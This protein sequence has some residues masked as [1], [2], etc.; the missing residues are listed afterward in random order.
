MEVKESNIGYAVSTALFY[1][2]CSGSMNF[3]NK[4]VLN[5]WEFHYPNFMVLCQLTLFTAVITGLRAA[6]KLTDNVVLSYTIERG[7]QLAVLSMLYITNVILALFALSGMNIPMYNAMRRCVPIAS[8]I[9]GPCIYPQRTTTSIVGSIILITAGTITAANG[10]LDF[11]VKSYSFGI[12]SVLSQSLYLLTL[13]RMG[14]EQQLGA[15]NTASA[16]TLTILYVNSVNCVPIVFLVVLMSGEFHSLMSE[17]P[18]W[19]EPGFLFALTVV[20]SFACVFSYSIFLCTTVNSALTTACVGV[21]KSALTTIIGMYTFGGV[22][23]TPLLIIGQLINLSGGGLY[24]FEKYRIQRAR[25]AALLKQ[26][27]AK[28]SLTQ[29]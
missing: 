16:K 23:A 2:I 14:A 6:G 22:A 19:H 5:S 18:H 4:W 13:Q 27:D 8:L 10:D 28:K 26:D 25:H 11:D 17:Y 9:L 3:I 29:A 21:I 7:R 1:G 24:T 12:C 20:T 15:Y